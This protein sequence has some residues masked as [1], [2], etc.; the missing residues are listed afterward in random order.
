[1]TA[2]QPIGP[3]APF[4]IVKDLGRAI[5][6]YTTRLGFE[7]RFALPEEDPFFAIVGRGEVQ[8]LLKAVADDV[9]GL[10]NVERHA[11]APWDA[12]VHVEDPDALAAEVAELGAT[13]HRALTDREDGL[14]GFEVRDPGGYVLF[15]GRPND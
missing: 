13:F 5:E 12:Y 6:H 15:F 7:L 10:A 8:L 2:P 11:W 4:F 14:R 9:G 3:I 1:M